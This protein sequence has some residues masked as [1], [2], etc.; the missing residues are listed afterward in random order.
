MATKNRVKNYQDQELIKKLFCVCVCVDSYSITQKLIENGADVN[1]ISYLS[2][3]WPQG[4]QL[5]S[6]FEPALI[7]ATRH[8]N[9]S[10][11]EL[12]INHGA[13]I[14]KA[15]SFNMSAMHWAVSLN[16]NDTVELLLENKA[17]YNLLDHKN[18]TPIERAIK[19]GNV[20]IMRIFANNNVSLK[21]KFR[22]YLLAAIKSSNCEILW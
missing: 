10:I 9:V 7:T 3:N 11:C 18:Q 1:R 21:F 12:L 14:N 2:Y 15:D 16:L 19:N 17:D 8:G 22:D 13:K 4:G 5:F 20:E 6:S